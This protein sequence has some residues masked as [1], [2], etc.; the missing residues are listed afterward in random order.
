[1]IEKPAKIG[2]FFGQTLINFFS[3]FLGGGGLDQGYQV[4]FCNLQIS[5]DYNISERLFS[6]GELRA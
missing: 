3:F 1:M 2:Y 6:E 5:F 4:P